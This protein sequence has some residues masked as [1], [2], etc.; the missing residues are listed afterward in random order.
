MIANDD[1]DGRLLLTTKHESV[2]S[3]KPCD[4]SSVQ[5]RS[6][7]EADTRIFLQFGTCISPGPQGS[8][9]AHSWQWCGSTCSALFQSTWPGPVLV[10]LWFWKIIQRHSH[11]QHLCSTRPSKSLA[12][13]LFHALTGCDTTHFLGYGK[14]T[15][16]QAWTCCPDLTETLI[17]LTQDPTLLTLASI[18]MQRLERFVVLMYT[19]SYSAARV[20]D[21]RVHLFTRGRRSLEKLPPTQAA[22][23]EHVKRALLQASY[24]WDKAT[25]PVHA[26][27]DFNTMVKSD[28]GV[29]CSYWTSLPDANKACTILLR[30]GCLKSCI[31][32]C[33]C[34]KAVVLCTSLCQCEGRCI[35]NTGDLWYHLLCSVHYRLYVNR[36]YMQYD[37]NCMDLNICG[38]QNLDSCTP[39][40]K[41]NGTFFSMW[42]FSNFY[43]FEFLEN[44]SVSNISVSKHLCQISLKSTVALSTHWSLNPETSW[45]F[46]FKLEPTMCVTRQNMQ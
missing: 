34:S 45:F 13:P 4:M 9:C 21:A 33:K 20:K 6:H 11:P 19:R 18:H 43:F 46:D 28:Q 3:N 27:S 23:F 32:N 30:C 8:L 40:C 25:A 14:K 42:E 26:L 2:L 7:S 39:L 37:K 36:S 16:W 29:W 41:S 17:D 22:L 31:G 24:H 10:M 12:L 38:D 44:L 5:P 15:V 1:M 35:N